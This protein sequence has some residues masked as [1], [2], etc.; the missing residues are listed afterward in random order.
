VH[1]ARSILADYRQVG[2]KV[3]RRFQGGKEGTLWYY[4]QLAAIF[5]QIGPHPLSAEL[6]RVV[7]EMDGLAASQRD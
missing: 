1:N 2:E 6:A 5:Q 4:R 7:E 3:W